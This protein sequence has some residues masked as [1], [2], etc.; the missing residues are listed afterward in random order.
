M[1]TVASQVLNTELQEQA[2][3]L[4]M[5]ESEYADTIRAGEKAQGIIARQR[6]HVEEICAAIDVLIAHEKSQQVESS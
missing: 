5:L 2:E 6:R 1:S 3:K 4:K